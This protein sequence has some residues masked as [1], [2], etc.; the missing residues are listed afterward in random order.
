MN[1]ADLRQLISR[2]DALG[3]NVMSDGPLFHH[4]AYH[5]DDSYRSAHYYRAVWAEDVSIA[6]EWGLPTRE[7][8]DEPGHLWAKDNGFPDPHVYSFWI[9]VFFQGELVDRVRAFDVD[10]G[11]AYLPRY[12]QHRTD[13]GPR[14]DYKHATWAFTVDPWP[15]TL[16]KLVDSL[17][18]KGEFDS[19][20]ARASFVQ[21]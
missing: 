14:D 19:Y 5:G 16:T 13:D 10:G 3:W 9:D 17:S 1:L 12:N 18:N 2:T 8:Q 11:R 7:A 20:F 4:V 21:A 15:Y 6:L